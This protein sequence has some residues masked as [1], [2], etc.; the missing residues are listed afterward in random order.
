MFGV[1]PFGLMFLNFIGMVLFAVFVV[2]AVRWMVRG[3]RCGGAY[4]F[5]GPWGHHHGGRKG[6]GKRGGHRGGHKGHARWHDQPRHWDSRSDHAE[7]GSERGERG[8]SGRGE[9]AA[10]DGGHAG[11]G[12]RHRRDDALS[13]AR[14]RLARSEISVDEYNSIR[15]ALEA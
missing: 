14:V 1:F 6:R 7:H 11:A 12:R 15:A 3:A 4:S 8:D 10:G 9:L 13:L 2:M 5:A